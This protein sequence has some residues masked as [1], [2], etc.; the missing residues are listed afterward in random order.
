MVVFSEREEKNHSS[1]LLLSVRRIVPRDIPSEIPRFPFHDLSSNV[2]D[3]NTRASSGAY[4]RLLRV[5]LRIDG[6]GNG[7]ARI[8]KISGNRKPRKFR[9]P[10][11][12]IAFKSIIGG[13]GGERVNDLRGWQSRFNIFIS[14]AIPRF[15]NIYRRSVHFSRVSRSYKMP[16]LIERLT[17]ITLMSGPDERA[18]RTANLP[19]FGKL[20]LKPGPPSPPSLP[21]RAMNPF[22]GTLRF[23]FPFRIQ[24]W[25]LVYAESNYL[26]SLPFPALYPAFRIIAVFDA[27]FFANFRENIFVDKISHRSRKFNIRTE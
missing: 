20:T 3:N 7:A 22:K 14:T 11:G 12:V 27:S 10:D 19:L 15:A 8:F 26:P 9:Y 18:A 6:K 5:A 23:N 17:S 4:L 13:G 2:R 25:L 21:R 24:L 16:S 1:S